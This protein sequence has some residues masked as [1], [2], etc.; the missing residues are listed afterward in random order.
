MDVHAHNA[1]AWDRE[2]E[3][4][5]PWTV[6][7]DHAHVEAARRGAF[8][9]KL[10]NTQSMPRSWL[11]KDLRGVRIL[12]LASGGGQQAPLLAAAGADVTVFD[13]SAR[14][15]AQD[16]LVAQREGL[17]LRTEQ[18]DMRDLSRFPDASFDVVFNPASVLFVPDVRPVWRECH[19]VL[20]AGGELLSGFLNPATYLFDRER[21]ADGELVAKHALPYSDLQLPAATRTALFGDAPLEFS[22]TLTDLIGGQLAAGFVIVDLYE[23]RWGDGTPLDRLM[24]AL[25]ATRARKP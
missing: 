22:H 9:L 17:A 6:P 4:Q 5:N 18:G 11:S 20:R 24:P 19:R 21:E 12:A 13:A 14:Q 2:V 16:R 8:S 1:A 15:L 25:L 23:D 3:H 10:T 7:V